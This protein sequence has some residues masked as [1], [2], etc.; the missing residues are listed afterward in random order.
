MEFSQIKYAVFQL[1]LSVSPLNFQIKHSNNVLLLL[2]DAI[3]NMLQE[4]HETCGQNHR[5]NVKQNSVFDHSNL[6][7]LKSCAYHPI[8]LTCHWIMWGAFH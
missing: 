7:V 2:A 4:W 3:S 5:D 1:M 8:I 6:W